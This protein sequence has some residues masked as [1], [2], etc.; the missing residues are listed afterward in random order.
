LAFFNS[1]QNKGARQSLAQIE[2][3][4]K[5]E[6]MQGRKAEGAHYLNSKNLSL[7][8]TPRLGNE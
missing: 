6:K 8:L 3:G 2:W 1:K 5:A 4:G 7:M